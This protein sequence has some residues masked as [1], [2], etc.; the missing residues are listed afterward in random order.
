M[1][2]TAHRRREGA[3]ATASRRC[4]ATCAPGGAVLTDDH[5]PIERITDRAL[6]EYLREG[7]PGAE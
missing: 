3:R 2:A 4:C 6:L 1:M 7:A 5:S